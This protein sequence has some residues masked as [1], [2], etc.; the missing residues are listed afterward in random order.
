MIKVKALIPLAC[1]LM[2]FLSA[3]PAVGEQSWEEPLE[4]PEGDVV[5]VPD[6]PVA[7]HGEADILEVSVEP[8]DGNVNVTMT[9]A[10]EYD[11]W[12]SYTVDVV[13]DEETFTFM[14]VILLGYT[15][16]DEAGE[17]YDVAGNASA[18]GTLLSWVV[19]A[20]DL[21]I[22]AESSIG[23]RSA[24]ATVFEM[25]G[26][27]D[28]FMDMAGEGSGPGPGPGPGDDEP[29]RTDMTFE[30]TALEKVKWTMK[31][32]VEGDDAKGMRGDIDNNTDGTVTQAEVDEYIEKIKE[33]TVNLSTEDV[34]VTLDGKDP[35]AV[36]YDIDIVGATGSA[37]SNATIEFIMMLEI[38]FPTP[39]DKSSHV[40]AWMDSEDIGGDEPWENKPESVYKFAAPDGWK[41]D[42]GTMP[43]GLKQY[44]KDGDSVIEM[45][46]DDLA[47]DW[48]TTLGQMSELTVKKKTKKEDNPG[49]GAVL[50]SVAVLGALLVIERRRRRG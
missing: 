25:G 20:D 11:S 28:T 27:V 17:F 18:D 10:G 45:T 33:L 31:T 37:S 32:Y 16:N 34:N 3:V 29:E 9:L 6:T 49:F 40:L 38:E 4:D 12:G 19:A 21:G 1:I 13:V 39:E 41:F 30:F 14:K 24:T 46:G 47:Q 44:L 48:N 8:E 26:D 5:K 2:L 50:A 22:D 36:E 23:I 35:T 7:G 42:K 43:S 15:V